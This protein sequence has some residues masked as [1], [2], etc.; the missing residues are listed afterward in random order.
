MYTPELPFPFSRCGVSVVAVWHFNQPP[1]GLHV[2]NLTRSCCPGGFSS[3]ILSKNLF[4][5]GVG[6]S[7]DVQSGGHAFL[8]EDHLQPRLQ[9]KWADVTRYQLGPTAINDPRLQPFPFYPDTH[10][11]DLVLLD[12]H[13]LRTS[14]PQTAGMSDRLLISQ[15][16]IGLQAISVSGTIVIKLSRPE[17]VVTAKILFML[18]VLSLSLSTW[19]PVYMHATRATFYAVA[20]GVGYGQQGNR[21]PQLLSGLKALWMDLTYGGPTG[22][23]RALNAADLDFILNDVELQSKFGNRLQQLA[24]HIWLVQSESL[25]GWSQA[26]NL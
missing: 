9:L 19:K 21:W 13:P 1:H 16:I 22:S 25:R 5:T 26:G 11:F 6:L 14:N 10:L 7:L 18:D 24:Q 8:L 20:K 17:R 12:G 3:Y 4:A 15:L 2:S 23:G